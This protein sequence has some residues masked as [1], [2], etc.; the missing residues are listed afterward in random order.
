MLINHN[1]LSN[2]IQWIFFIRQSA[3]PRCHWLLYILYWKTTF[4]HEEDFCKYEPFFKIRKIREK[5]LIVCFDGD[6]TEKKN[7]FYILKIM[8]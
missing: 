8:L 6:N 1:L 3:D 2:L 5:N 7:K 4:V